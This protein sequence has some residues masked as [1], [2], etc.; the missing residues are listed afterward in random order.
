MADVQQLLVSE[1]KTPVLVSP[2]Q[3]WLPTILKTYHSFS[4]V[5]IKFCETRW[6]VKQAESL[7]KKTVSVLFAM[8]A[9]C[10]VRSP[11]TPL[12]T[13]NLVDLAVSSKTVLAFLVFIKKTTTKALWFYQNNCQKQTHIGSFLHFCWTEGFCGIWTFKP[14]CGE[15]HAIF[16]FIY[17]GTPVC[18]NHQAEFSPFVPPR[19][20]KKKKTRLVWHLS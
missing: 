6:R 19:T 4:R 8:F 16:S 17:S 10:T 5:W 13:W 14:C 7:K 2:W 15:W 12:S 18:Q 20:L 9:D 3:K 11:W 1:K